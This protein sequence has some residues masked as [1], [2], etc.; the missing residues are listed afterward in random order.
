[1]SKL[2]PCAVQLRVCRERY[3][4]VCFKIFSD[5]IDVSDRSHVK[6]SHVNTHT[7]THENKDVFWGGWICL[8]ISGGDG[9]M[10]GCL[11]ANLSKCIH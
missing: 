8:V 7:H 10:I 4:V 9:V 1:M 5:M 2:E 3:A 6:W 11:C